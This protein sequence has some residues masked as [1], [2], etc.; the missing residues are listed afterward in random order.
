VGVA[1]LLWGLTN[2]TAVIIGIAAAALKRLRA[3]RSH[4]AER[5]FSKW[6]ANLS[7]GVDVEQR[8]AFLPVLGLNT[9]VGL[10]IGVGFVC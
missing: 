4:H 6:Q 3:N 1:R 8:K 2:P 5:Q 7:L 10:G 9:L